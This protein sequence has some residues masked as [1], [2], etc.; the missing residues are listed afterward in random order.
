MNPKDHPR[1]VRLRPC[2]Q[3]GTYLVAHLGARFGVHHSPCTK[4]GTHFV[5]HLG[6]HLGV[7]PSSCNATVAHLGANTGIHISHCNAHL[8]T[9]LGVHR[10]HKPR[11]ELDTNTTSEDSPNNVYWTGSLS[12]PRFYPSTPVNNTN[13]RRLTSIHKPAIV[14]TLTYNSRFC[15][16]SKRKPH[17]HIDFPYS[18]VSHINDIHASISCNNP[19]LFMI[20][21]IHIKHDNVIDSRASISCNNPCSNSIN[22]T[23]HEQ[24]ILTQLMHPLLPSLCLTT[25]IMTCFLLLLIS[26]IIN[27]IIIMNL[28]TRKNNYTPVPRFVPSLVQY[29]SVPRFVL[30]L[31]QSLMHHLVHYTASK[32]YHSE[33]LQSAQFL[34]HPFGNFIIL[35][36]SYSRSLYKFLKTTDISGLLSDY[37][38]T[39][40]HHIHQ[41]SLTLAQRIHLNTYHNKQYDYS[42]PVSL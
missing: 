3:P 9:Q 6:A 26:I 36:T 1:R 5:A 27:Y 10:G 35:T 13:T 11:P 29:T 20:C 32:T 7:H 40:L 4:I 2:T 14:H 19:C 12:E 34:A 18:S 23:D 17:Y 39:F 37:T 33:L 25:I 31:V 16:T 21:F 28:T 24:T 41:H 8:G 22:E 38:D 30:R 15:Y 42:T